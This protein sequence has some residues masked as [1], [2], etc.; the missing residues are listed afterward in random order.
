[1]T[2]ETRVCEHGQ[3]RRQCDI[4]ELK[5]RLAE[6]D[7]AVTALCEERDWY[8]DRLDAAEKVIYFYANPLNQMGW[9]AR[10][11]L[12]KHAKREGAK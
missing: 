8:S 4:C 12:A 6:S 1:M 7:A 11:Y 2:D 5:K 3:L 9:Q 10:A